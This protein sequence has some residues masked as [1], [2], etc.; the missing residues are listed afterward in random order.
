MDFIHFTYALGGGVHILPLH[1]SYAQDNEGFED[2]E[3]EFADESTDEFTDVSIESNND[4]DFFAEEEEVLES[5]E[6]QVAEDELN[7]ELQNEANTSEEVFLDE[8][9]TKKESIEDENFLAEGESTSD[10]AKELEIAE[11]AED[12]S[13]N[14]QV[15]VEPEEVAE[16]KEVGASEPDL[17][18]EANLHD[19]YVRYHSE[20]MTDEQWDYIAGAKLS[21]VYTIQKGD[22]LWDLSRTFFGDGNYWPKIWAVNSAI[23]NP[24]LI[25][26]QNV[27]RFILGSENEPPMFTISEGK[28][29]GDVSGIAEEENVDITL[30]DTQI[31]DLTKEVGELEKELNQEFSEAEL[32]DEF[33]TDEEIEGL[34]IPPPE[35]IIRPVTQVFPP[36]LPQWKTLADS[37]L[38]STTITMVGNKKELKTPIVNLSY[39]IDENQPEGIGKVVG[40]EGGGTVSASYQYIYVRV[41]KGS[42]NEG[43]KFIVVG[44]MGPLKTEKGIQE[45]AII[46]E[47]QG[48]IIIG[49]KLQATKKYKSNA[50]D[51]YRAYVDN[52]INAIKVGSEVLASDYTTVSVDKVGRIPAV[53]GLIIGGEFDNKEIYF[54]WKV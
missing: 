52:A 11:E 48:Q 7:A 17:Q 41:R 6:E 53:S 15:L 3:E 38:E 23:T 30:E 5:N 1:K 24:H 9:E 25:E 22:T 18:F 4:D 34:V 45:D 32:E 51:V 20:S 31:E 16:I 40:V 14:D 27:I 37:V 44:S 49:Q 12:P 36:S 35:T 39:Y 28:K 2:F 13:K 54:L 46:Y 50:F 21:E 29:D 8:G 42:V 47:V 33:M 26:P 19:I 43:D 10:T